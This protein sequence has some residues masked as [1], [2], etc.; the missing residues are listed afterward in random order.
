MHFSRPSSLALLFVVALLTAFSG[1]RPIDA[2]T[3]APLLETIDL[4]PGLDVSRPNSL[5]LNGATHKLYV[6]S[7]SRIK[8]IDTTSVTPVAAFQFEDHS[9]DFNF[10]GL[11]L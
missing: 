4:A 7:A 6:A 10:N 3:T 8:V 9:S 5:A 2:G 11:A 1:L